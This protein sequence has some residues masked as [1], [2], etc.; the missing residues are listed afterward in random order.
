M[1]AAAHLALPNDR[2]AINVEVDSQMLEEPVPQ[3]GGLWLP[4]H[5]LTRRTLGRHHHRAG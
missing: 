5:N 4:D 2:L 3:E 1:P